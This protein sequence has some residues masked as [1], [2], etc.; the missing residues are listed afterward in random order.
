MSNQQ[1]LL[2]L[3]ALE[4]ENFQHRLAGLTA[5][6]QVAWKSRLSFS[7]QNTIAEVEILAE[8]AGVTGIVCSNEVFLS[9]LLHQQVDFSPP[10]NRRGITLDDYQGSYM[11]TPRSKIPVIIINPLVNLVTVPYA[12]FV[13]KR[14]ITKLTRPGKWFPETKFT[15]ELAQES[16][17]NGIYTRWGEDAAIIAIDIETPNPPTPART[18][19]C[20][21]YCAY[22]PNTGTTECIVIPTTNLYWLTWVRRFNTLKQPKVMQ[23]GLYD[24][25]YFMRWNCPVFN[26]LYDTQH[27]FHSWYSELP[28]RLDFITAFAV[29]RVRYWKDDGKTGN[30]SDRYRY[31]AKDCWAT[32]NSLLALVR[33]CDD[34]ALSNYIQEFPLVFPCL[35]CELEGLACDVEQLA[36]VKAQKEQEVLTMQ[37]GLEKML[38][39]PGFNVNSP[40][41]VSTL[42]AVLGCRHL[43]STDKAAMLKAKAA[44]PLNNRILTRV[45]DIRERRKLISTYLSA[46]KLFNGRW[47]YRLNPAGTDTGRLASTE[48]SYW[49]GL[50]I[51][52]IPTGNSVKQ[53]C[54]ADFGWLLGEIDKEQS[55]ARCVGYLAGETKLIELVEGPNDYHSWNA[56]AFFG[57]PYDSIYDN[58]T[59]KP[60]NKK[61]RYLSKRTNHGANYNMGPDVMLDTMGP[62]RV[63]E[64]KIILKLPS[65]WGLRRVCKYL[66]ERY[67]ETYPRVKNEFYDAIIREIELTG[68][69]TS[70]LGWVRVFFSKPSRA[71]SAKPALNAAVAHGPQ[72]LSVGIVNKE[73]YAI[74]WEQIYGSLRQK[75]RIKAQI[76]D[77]IFFQYR[78]N[79]PD[80]PEIINQ[81]MQ[82]AL[83]IRGADGI[84]RK[85][86]IPSSVSFGKRRWSELK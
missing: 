47:H 55:E 9:K 73:F 80:V 69:L 27:L 11:E 23:N 43:G 8:K 72:N 57:V 35:T 62:Q 14:F 16:T 59:K 22:F 54:I 50:Q 74:W 42:F 30:A 18:M 46:E 63:S 49:C 65:F 12:S 79:C 33:E 10:N 53:C 81:L 7:V 34:F 15:W 86:L 76:H 45:T 29:R 32:L 77:S 68:K 5:G 70:A 19:D 56:Q 20:V 44:H 36:I 21:G 58:E 82:T 51:Q 84:I 85:M 3:G 67:E 1:I 39:T 24:N 31:N 61:L 48:S 52:N 17:I 38:R 28:K 25:L 78:E 83:H 41:Q 13:A 26:W 60:K 40:K 71:P 37:A 64:A 6:E 2:H 75:S 66:L 4:D